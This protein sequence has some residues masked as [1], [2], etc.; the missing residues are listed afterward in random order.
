MADIRFDVLVLA[1]VACTEKM[2]K[3]S[4]YIK[5]HVYLQYKLFY[6]LFHIENIKCR[7]RGSRLNG[8]NDR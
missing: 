2:R 1:S 7:L 3:F 6:N 5:V 8:N 4:R